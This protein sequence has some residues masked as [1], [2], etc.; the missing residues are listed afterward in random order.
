MKKCSK[1]NEIKNL[2]FFY[3]SPRYSGGL[4]AMCKICI[5]DNK[6]KYVLNNKEKR[7]ES[8]KKYYEKNKEKEKLY[9][10]NNKEKIK[11][12]MKLYRLN[13]K[14]KFIL[15]N[16]KYRSNNKEQIKIYRLN[17]K[18]KIKESWK[19]YYK[20]NDKTKFKIKIRNYL[21]RGIKNN[22]FYKKDY[23]EKVLGCNLEYLKKY[24]EDN[25]QKMY[26]IPINEAEE[27]LHIDHIIPLSTAK[28]EEDIIKLNHYTNL[29]YLYASHNLEKS[30][31]LWYQPSLKNLK[32]YDII[33]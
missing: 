2:S 10:K 32:S 16:K 11:E 28:T 19:K 25:F 9:K 14:E 23:I 3:K 22:N 17:N 20:T 6:K 33:V 31:K 30:D 27:I 12:Q 4:T 1:C 24:L 7:K 18:E 13:N 26:G 8:T 15:A 5:L 21:K 29:Q